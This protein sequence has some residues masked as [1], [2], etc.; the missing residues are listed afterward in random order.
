[1]I[2]THQNVCWETSTKVISDRLRRDHREG[3]GVV[4]EYKYPSPVWTNINLSRISWMN[5]IDSTLKIKGCHNANF[6]VNGGTVGYYNDNIWCPQWRQN[7]IMTILCFHGRNYRKLFASYLAIIS[8]LQ[9]AQPIQNSVS[10]Q[11]KHIYIYI[12]IL[13]SVLVFKCAKTPAARIH[14]IVDKK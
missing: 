11:T 8:T 1:M 4:L 13:L 7:G 3:G 14:L 12:H 5:P 2:K 10:K 6:I 9:P